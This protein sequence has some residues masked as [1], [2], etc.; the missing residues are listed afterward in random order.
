M[1]GPVKTKY[2]IVGAGIAGIA[3]AE[4]IRE[5]D[6]DG[7]ILV[8][9][10][11]SVPPYCRPL[12]VEVLRGE[13][14][15]EEIVLRKPE[16]YEEKGVS[17]ITGDRAAR[18]DARKKRLLLESGKVVEWERLLV[19]PGSAPFAP[20][21]AGIDKVPTSTLYCY[22]DVE[23]LRSLCKPGARALLIGVGLIG[24][25]AMI[26]LRELGV[27]V[28]AVELMGKVLPLTLDSRAAGYAQRKLEENGIEIHVGTAVK[29]L[30]RADGGHPFFART[31][32]G[33]EIGF[34][35]V[36]Q[37]A[38]MRPDLALLDGTGIETGRG[39]K[40]G[41]D[42]QTSAPGIYAAGDVTEYL[43][44]I[45]GR[46]EVHAHWVNA[47]RQGRNAGLSMAGG[48]IEPYEPVAVNS[49]SVF[50]LPIITMGASRIDSPDGMDVHISESPEMPS[51]MRLLVRDGRLVGATFINDVDRAGV[52]QYLLREKVDVGDVAQSLLGQGIEGMDFLYRL[53]NEAV[54]GDVEWPE[55]MYQIEWFK[56][57]H[58]HTRWG[59]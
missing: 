4:A 31:D 32:S 17:L 10:G 36:V 26:A 33:V 49:I 23:I 46:P 28:V 22:D 54:K 38:G 55:T 41:E 59:K 15:L 30:G 24:V 40:V 42:M 9:N 56:K 27:D 6:R 58:G 14:T 21:I 1:A 19:A 53:H 48:T 16:W 5:V 29:E 3:A 52:Y 50:G 35:F 25:Q 20:P 37:A 57:D 47:Y 13:R 44:W 51:Y 12:I 8:V 11:E 7:G 43:D 2:A 39:I 18:L 45:E 34:D